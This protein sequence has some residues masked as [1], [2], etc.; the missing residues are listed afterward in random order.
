MP[1]PRTIEIYQQTGG[2]PDPGVDTFLNSTEY[3]PGFDFSINVDLNAFSDSRITTYAIVKN[4]D[5]SYGQVVSRN[6][7]VLPVPLHVSNLTAWSL[8]ELDATTIGEGS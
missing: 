6:V 4:P 2:A 5:S 3:F 8:G 7:G 1:G